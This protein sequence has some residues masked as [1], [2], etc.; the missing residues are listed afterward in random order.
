MLTI[1]HAPV[2][3]VRYARQVVLIAQ[4]VEKQ[5]ATPFAPVAVGMT[6]L[7]CQL[8]ATVYTGAALNFGRA[9]GPSV[10]S[11]PRSDLWVYFV[12]DGLG[13]LLAAA[14]YAVLKHIK[15]VGALAAHLTRQLSEPQS[16]A[17]L[18]GSSG[19]A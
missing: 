2:M 16:A 5:K 19:L 18:D 12:G 6:L 14:V 11:G 7:A 17:R 15:Y 9:L 1:A 13:A 8:L 3:L 10:V 4:A